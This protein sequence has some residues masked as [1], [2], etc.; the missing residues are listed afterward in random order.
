MIALI[1]SSP[2]GIFGGG[3]ANGTPTVTVVIGTVNSEWDT[4]IEQIKPCQYWQ[5]QR[6]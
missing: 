2:F 5:N 3:G 4:K 6:H 1:I